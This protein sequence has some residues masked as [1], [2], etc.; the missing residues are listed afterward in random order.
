[1]ELQIIRHKY[2][3]DYF[4][5]FFPPDQVSAYSYQLQRMF[6]SGAAVEGDYFIV[7]DENNPYM[8][9]E[10]YRNNSRRI[11]ERMPEINPKAASDP[12][13]NFESIKL[14]FEFLAD[15]EYYYG[16]K[17]QLEIVIDKNHEL[18]DVM[19][20]FAIK[21][22]FEKI[23]EYEEYRYKV[24]NDIHPD[25][26]KEVSF[27]SFTDIEPEERFK[28]VYE[29]EMS[30][31]EFRNTDTESLY[32]D[33]LDDSYFSEE[34]WQVINFDNVAVGFMM[35]V[36][37]SGLKNKIRLIN[38]NIN[39]KVKEKEISE[40]IFQRMIQI[41]IENRIENLEFIVK[42]SEGLLIKQLQDNHAERTNTYIRYIN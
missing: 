19:N 12:Q 1:M 38:Y 20:D 33:Y 15:K 24:D 40:S 13:K 34:L 9:V 30:V 39:N 22:D 27:K 26:S 17:D 5:D 32:Q 29:N 3:E 10:I 37:T 11:W 42:E 18:S 7:K 2:S 4:R 41:A 25:L 28:L 16:S 8:Q 36:F 35:P 6:E 23:G 14:I 31:S 21:Y